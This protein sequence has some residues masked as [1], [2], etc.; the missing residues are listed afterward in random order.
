MRNNRSIFVLSIS[1]IF[2]TVL[3]DKTESTLPR[4][5]IDYVLKYQTSQIYKS[6]KDGVL[7]PDTGEIE[8]IQRN[9]PT[10]TSEQYF[11]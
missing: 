4:S 10:I 2:S 6:I 3:M 1:L 8:C 5:T 11:N 9:R 7:E